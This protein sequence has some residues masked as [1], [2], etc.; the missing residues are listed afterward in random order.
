MNAAAA[1]APSRMS[2]LL[3]MVPY[4]LAREGI[5][6]EQAA[7]DLQV[8]PAQLTKDL[9][10]LFVCGIP[11]Y[12]HGDLIDLEFS[13][14]VVSVLFSAGMD[15]PLRLTVTEAT[16]LLVAL[17]SLLDIPGVVDRGAARRA[18][19]K[20][21]EAVGARIPTVGSGDPDTEAEE[22][23]TY[24]ALREATTR[25][26]AVAIRY[27]SATRDTVSDRVVDPIGLQVVDNQT[28]LEAW[29]RSSDGVRLFRFDRVE[30]AGVLDEPSNPP[31]DR[32]AQSAVINENPDL[33]SVEID[34]DTDHLWVLDYYLAE[35][36]ED[37][38]ERADP[39]APVRARL[40]YGSREWLVR[41][42]LGFS[43]SVRVISD[44]A[45]AA[46]VAEAADAARNRYR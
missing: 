7:Q 25:R 14:G 41:F 22:T 27:Y 11:G 37:L 40:V 13:E 18:I 1:P 29:C 16:P 35:P 45:V 26:R 42:I 36:L 23:P 32:P 10:Q 46:T 5:S 12:Y 15:R 8:T 9:E 3:A 20:I 21:E 31:T 2:R 33:P 34:I 19:A 38:E 43:G 39:H 6:I 30:R 4:F 44:D 24:R 17:R 28:Y